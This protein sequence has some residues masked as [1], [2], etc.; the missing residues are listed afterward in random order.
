MISLDFQKIKKKHKN[1]GNNC[2]ICSGNIA[3]TKFRS[4]ISPN[5]TNVSFYFNAN[6]QKMH[7]GVNKF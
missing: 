6:V 7:I 4:N 2:Q 5:K 1:N 3:K